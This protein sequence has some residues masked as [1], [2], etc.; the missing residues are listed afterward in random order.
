MAEVPELAQYADDLR[1]A[2]M[3]WYRERKTRH[4]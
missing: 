3:Q 1:K 2:E 4:H